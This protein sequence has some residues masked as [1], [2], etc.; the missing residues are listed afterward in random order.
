M[1][2][3]RANSIG[4]YSSTPG[5][6]SE[7]NITIHP[8]VDRLDEEHKKYNERRYNVVECSETKCKCWPYKDPRNL[9]RLPSPR[10]SLVPHTPEPRQA[11]EHDPPV[12]VASLAETARLL[13]LSQYSVLLLL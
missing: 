12:A 1:T 11:F 8:T 5:S 4:R 2:P 9:N 10:S 7:S 6:K 3:P 13:L